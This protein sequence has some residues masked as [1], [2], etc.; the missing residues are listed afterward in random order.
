MH[1][2]EILKKIGR[3]S[4][5]AFL[6]L[7]AVACSK[8]NQTLTLTDKQLVTA[9]DVYEWSFEEG[10]LSIWES[11]PT[12]VYDTEER[13]K[14]VD[15]ELP[16]VADGPPITNTSGTVV[17]R[18]MKD[19]EAEPDPGC[20]DVCIEST[21]SRCSYKKFTYKWWMQRGDAKTTA[22][23]GDF[24]PAKSISEQQF[25]DYDPNVDGNPNTSVE[26]RRYALL[27][28]ALG[29]VTVTCTIN[30]PDNASSDPGLV[31]FLSEL[32]VG[33]IVSSREEA[34]WGKDPQWLKSGKDQIDC[35]QYG[36][37]YEVK[38]VT[39]PTGR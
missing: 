28:F 20:V 14:C 8:P 36:D 25:P 24:M 2:P 30:Y 21:G 17:S 18:P 37:P 15:K 33:D 19:G 29:E 35:G 27:T 11:A 34:G 12:I 9:T 26:Y 6:L 3:W 31:E 39:V 7:G 16:R 23:T 5:P 22:K 32:K 4:I 10:E 13:S 38:V 1:S